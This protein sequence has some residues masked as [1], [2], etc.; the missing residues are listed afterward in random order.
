M[1]DID[2]SQL[3]QNIED[4]ISSG[5]DRVMSA[6][7]ESGLF[8]Q[9]INQDTGGSGR[10]ENI[11]QTTSPAAPQIDTASAL[12][13]IEESLTAQAGIG[14][15]KTKEVLNTTF[16]E[17][18]ERQR[19]FSVTLLQDITRNFGAELQQLA[20]GELQEEFFNGFK[21]IENEGMRVV[22]NTAA[23]IRDTSSEM[24]QYMDLDD[25]QI[26]TS[27][28]V[29]SMGDTSIN[30]LKQLDKDTQVASAKFAKAMGLS[31]E[32]VGDLIAVNF[33]ETGKSSDKILTDVLAM[34]EGVGKA[35]G[36]PTK[37]MVEGIT[38]VKSDMETFT[39]ITVEGAAKMVASLSQVGLSLSSF[40]GMLSGY[41][42]FDAAADKIGDLS[43]MF[44][45]QMDAMEMM[46]LANEDE[47][48]F[49]H[50]MR[51]QLLD[52]GMD[53]E[54]MSKTR[55][56]ALASTL[57]ME[58]QE[59]KYFM[60]TGM[61][62]A[63]QEELAASAQEA[64]TK[65]RI[66]SL[67][68]L[69]DSM[70]KI[71]RSSENLSAIFQNIQA[72]FSAG[73][74]TDTVEAFAGTQ[75]RLTE[76]FTREIG[77]SGLAI[78][79]QQELASAEAVSLDY[80]ERFIGASIPLVEGTAENLIQNTKTAFKSMSSSAAAAAADIANIVGGAFGLN[81]LS[82]DIENYINSAVSQVQALPDQILKTME[83]LNNRNY[84]VQVN[85]N[86]SSSAVSEE[87]TNSVADY[88][89]KILKEFEK[90]SNKVDVNVD[91]ESIKQDIVNALSDGIN[92]G[93]SNSNHNIVVKISEQTLMDIIAKSST[94]NGRTVVLQGG[95]D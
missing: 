65:T 25:Y 68:L 5:F 7:S 37:Q 10:Q 55:Q 33:A 66:E 4:A 29:K 60:S 21:G 62:M 90:Q 34:A 15:K 80:I 17:M 69:D 32:E 1:P 27:D 94:T 9:D 89:E 79:L 11:R 48:E 43:A 23:V 20:V 87:V 16:E 77:V 85:A 82:S 41:R 59:M 84:S 57:G 38:E 39:D 73:D 42:D 58:V 64:S 63:S 30:L 46:Y 72:M 92:G 86:V 28:L 44:G 70:V 76:A 71:V 26:Y 19:S 12:I 53:V 6:M 40:K 22:A 95:S 3:S 67:E 31:M 13:D 49:L 24:Q 91:I 75:A 14:V 61:E 18:S 8:R 51:E 74:L 78:D 35:V 2:L 56:R 36:I 54:S 50:R 52:Q 47:G 81:N 83:T 88:I 45:V 93:F